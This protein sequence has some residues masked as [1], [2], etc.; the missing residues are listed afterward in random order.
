MKRRF[1][2]LESSKNATVFSTVRIV[3]LRISA[4]LFFFFGNATFC[5]WIQFATGT[6]TLHCGMCYT[7]DKKCKRMWNGNS[8]ILTKKFFILRWNDAHFRQFVQGERWG[9]IDFWCD[10]C[11]TTAVLCRFF[12]FF[13]PF[14]V[15]ASTPKKKTATPN[16]FLALTFSSRPWFFIA[17]SS[18]YAWKP[19]TCRNPLKFENFRPNIFSWKRSEF[20]ALSAVLRSLPP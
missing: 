7:I 4:F 5:I 1:Q 3:S 9:K 8:W 17:K 6:L 13:R 14:F 18:L 2:R 19:K 15:S 20:W 11:T 12:A 10:S 16:F